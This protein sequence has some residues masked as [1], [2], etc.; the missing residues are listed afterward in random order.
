LKAFHFGRLFLSSA[1]LAESLTFTYSARYYV[2]GDL[3][4]ARQIWFV[5]HGYGQL[6]SYFIRNFQSLHEH[7]VAVVAP[8]G[9]S[10]FYLEDTVSRMKSG[11]DRVGACW[12]TKEQRLTDIA[13]YLTYL[14]T[15]YAKLLPLHGKIPTTVLGFSQGA[16]TASRWVLDGN[17]TFERL[18]LWA[19]ILPP[20]I[21]FSKGKETLKGKETILVYGNNDPFIQDQRFAEMNLLA[22]KLSINPTK[23]NFDGGHEIHTP[24]LLKLL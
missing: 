3:T 24:T 15:L 20:D 16:A 9:L 10:R 8:E 14:N 17:I 7:H 2:L 11:N 4:K 13:N 19:G 6:A 21:D 5:L 23:I 18:I 22:E 12:M 1:M